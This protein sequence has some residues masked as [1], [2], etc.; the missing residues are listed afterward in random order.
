MKQRLLLFF[1]L[2]ICAG[3]NAQE[4][5]PL[6]GSAD[7]RPGLFAFKNATIVVSADETINNGTLLIKGD[8]IEAVGKNIAV[9]AGYVTVDLKGKFIYPSF[10]D[11]FTTYGLPET[12]RQSFSFGRQSIFTTTK[13]GAYNWNE[14]IR[15]EMNAKSIFV[16]DDKKATDLKKLGFGTVNSV[17]TDGIVRGT[18]SVVSLADARENEVILLDDAAANYSFDKGTAKTDYPQSLTG[19]IALL[20]Q[21]YYDADWYKKQNKEYNISL[22]EFNNQQNLPQ[23][24][25]VGDWLDVLRADKLGDGFSKQ[26]IFKTDGDGYKRINEIK[27]TKASFIVPLNFPKAYDVEDQTDARKISFEQLKDWEMAPANLAAF[28]KAEINFAITTAGLENTLDFWANLRKA[29]SS[30]LTEKAALKALTQNPATMFNLYEKTGSISKGKI[31]NFFISTGNVFN[32]DQVILQNWVQ[33]KPYI[34]SESNVTGIKGNYNL[35]IAGLGNLTLKIAGTALADEAEIKRTGADSAT[36][37]ANLTR[38]GDVISLNFDLK[39]SPSGTVR[40]TGYLDSVAPVTFKGSSVLPDGTTGNFKA[41]FV[42][43]VAPS[44]RKEDKAEQYTAGT[45][46]YPFTA[47]GQ[48]EAPKQEAVLFKNATIWTNEAAGILKET[49][50]LIE[51]GKIKAIGKNLSSAKAKVIDASGKNL[52][53][54]I[55]DEHSHIAI[56]R[57]INEGSQSV[58]SEVSMADVLN[59][60]DVNIY[61]QLAGGVTTSHILHGSANPIGGRTALIKLRWG[62]TPEEMKYAGADVFIKFALGENV[63]QSNWGDAQTTRFPQTRMGVEQVFVDAF[64]R[65]KAYQL[66]WKNYRSSKDKNK[67]PPRKDMELDVIADILDNKTFIT[68]HS[69]VQSEINMLMHVADS[70]GFK[71]NTFTHIL[72]GYKVADK[73]AERKIAGSTFSD[74]WAYK[75][76]VADAIPYNGKIMNKVGVLTGFNSDDAEMARHLN[77]EAGKAVKYGGVSEEEAFKFV[78]LNP[79]KM[80]HIDDK[81]GSIKVGKDADLVLWS[82][83][84]LSSYAKAEKTFVDGI[85]YWDIDKDTEIRQNQDKETA[86]IIQKMIEAKG[87]GAKTQK[88]LATRQSYY[89]CDTIEGQDETYKY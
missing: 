1:T 36:V 64:S 43:E 24:F 12:P 38:N 56:S 21:T 67:T 33:G 53:P 68:C 76:E 22:K 45:A 55:I 86:R 2:L 8:Y 49:D 54:G 6:N 25:E 3:A 29:I 78:T 80:L 14:A 17:I 85:A 75:M 48:K 35:T 88:P 31:A 44:T 18:S 30:G 52:T 62:K 46:I 9:P 70:M 51:G 87:K 41:V 27:N 71:I 84:P 81:V 40:L 65:A 69:Y 47:F 50:L 72:E 7:K 73:M 59:S 63:K 57:G 16:I 15:P 10:I 13:K 20:K 23:I 74:W 58:T 77:I 89:D 37:K 60:E 39:K 26:Y 79:A 61:R 82:A 19:A 5:F 34:V 11:A 28:E 4:T 32:K 42:G 83:N 66:A